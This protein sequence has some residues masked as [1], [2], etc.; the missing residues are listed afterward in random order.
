[1]AVD[2][3]PPV[4]TAESSVAAD[5]PA[6]RRVPVARVVAASLT[7]GALAALV[8]TVVVFAGGPEYRITGAALVAFGAGW[9]LLAALSRRF[10]TQPQ[11]WARVP[12]VVMAASGLGLWAS[13]PGDAGLSAL[14][15]VWA[16][17]A[18]AL[19]VWM[20]AQVRRRLS[21][22]SRWL[23]YP[24][25]VAVG[26]AAVGAGFQDVATVRDQH[27]WAAPGT[28]YD[29]DGHRLHLDCHGTGGPTVVLENGLSEMSASWARI[30]PAVSRETRVCTHD[31]AGQGWSDEAS[32]PLD[33][34]E[35]AREL[36]RLLAV[37][38]EHGPFVM[39]GHSTGGTYALS[40]AHRYP[41]QVA[42]LV[43]L[44][45]SSPF[46]RTAIPS[47][48]RQYAVTRRAIALLPSLSRLGLGRLVPG[49]SSLPAPAADQ[50]ASFGA[51]TRGLRNVRD[52]QSVLLDVFAQAQALTSLHGKPLVVL[53]A[54]ENLTETPGWGAAQDRLAGLSTNSS[55]RLARATHVDLLQDSHDA[56]TSVDAVTD[57]VDAVRAGA[58]V[59]T[60]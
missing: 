41:D 47:F 52:E 43:L 46:Q 33:G 25:V 30:A 58:P 12:A 19:A 59:A 22:R 34:R 15:W 8:L 27:R 55:H 31:R 6:A 60:R 17:V 57:V 36:H 24:V 28:T 54:S 40:Y 45:S 32:H 3:H 38:G 10:T 44:D 16:P 13:A 35:T 56:A 18:L 21:G 4:P 7:V 23:L 9:A 26:L 48:S 1:M 39:V 37:A 51:G 2:T 50:V 29:V 20:F 5:G 14:G 53:T 11:D 42:G 49:R